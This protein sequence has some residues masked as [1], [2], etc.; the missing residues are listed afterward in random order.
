L[1]TPLVGT[2][3]E[4]GNHALEYNNVVSHHMYPYVSNCHHSNLGNDA[5]I[6][7]YIARD[8]TAGDLQCDP[9]IEAMQYCA[10]T[11]LTSV[12]VCIMSHLNIQC[13]LIP[14]VGK[15]C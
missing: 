1:Y 9:Y 5:T 10:Y 15:L 6:A 3:K 11:M 12:Q 8:V 14:Y 7:V 13:F 2:D 4:L